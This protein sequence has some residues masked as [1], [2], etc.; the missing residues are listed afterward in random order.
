MKEVKPP[1]TN[2]KKDKNSEETSDK[3]K[4]NFTGLSILIA[5]LALGATYTQ[6]YWTRH[7]YINSSRPYMW[8]INAQEIDANKNLISTAPQMLVIRIFNSPAEMLKLDWKITLDTVSKF[9]QKVY[10]RMIYPDT[11]SDWTASVTK[12]GFEE[13]KALQNEKPYLHR[14]ISIDYISLGGKK[15]YHYKMDQSYNSD[16]NQWVTLTEE[17]D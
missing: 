6:L 8:V 9:G 5:V 17:A 15:K 7:Q 4:R 2:V 11:K 1:K 14:I 16:I 12:E 10:N 13:L 3:R